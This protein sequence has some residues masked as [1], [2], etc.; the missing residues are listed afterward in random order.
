M[1]SK[2]PEKQSHPV[3]TGA[4]FAQPTRQQWSELALAGLPAASSLESLQTT[5]LEGLTIRVLYDKSPVA[6][7][8]SSTQDGTDG[9]SSGRPVDHTAW[10]NRLAITTAQPTDAVNQHILHGLLGGNTSV[11]IPLSPT[12]DLDALL[13]GVDLELAG[14]HSVCGL[15]YAPVAELFATHIES[16]SLDP[17]KVTCSFNA[18]PVGAWLDSGQEPTCIDTSIRLL[19]KFCATTSQA[20]PLSQGVLVNAAIHHNAGASAAQEL[21]AAIATATLY[22]ES[23]LDSGME[24]ITA[25]RQIVFKLACDADVVMGIVKLRSLRALWVHVLK[26]FLPDSTTRPDDQTL[27]ASSSVVVETSQRYLTVLDPWNNHLRNIAA[28]SAAA[29]GGADTIMVHPHDCI[30][31]QCLSE[32]PIV[33][34]RMAR[35][36][37]IILERESRLRDVCDPLAGSYAVDN[38]TWQLTELCWQTLSHMGDTRSWLEEIR[39]ARWQQGIADTHKR[40]LA[41]LHEEQIVVGVN[42][43]ESPETGNTQAA[44]IR[45]TQVDRSA[46]AMGPVRDAESFEQAHIAG[47][48]L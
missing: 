31:Q 47:A 46:N 36:L 28:C 22:L 24:L 3:A 32:D 43:Y 16:R 38:L 6:E 30:N 48:T 37:P 11:Q 1:P 20:L 12:H 34:M 40:R 26:Q 17:E 29:M 25:S 23:L 8:T 19:G 14:I 21:H 2:A 33:G 27:V 4:A 5:T 18:D 10:D 15:D 44:L 9:T 42:R 45:V 35:N 39:C 7:R 13:A 41:A